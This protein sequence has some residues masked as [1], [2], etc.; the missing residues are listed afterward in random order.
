MTAN[1]ECP[2]SKWQHQQLHIPA[3]KSKL[4]KGNPPPQDQKHH[5]IIPKIL[6]GGGV[7]GQQWN[8]Q[9][10]GIQKQRKNP[11]IQTLLNFSH[12]VVQHSI[13]FYPIQ[14]SGF[15]N[16]ERLCFRG[17]MPQPFASWESWGDGGTWVLFPDFFS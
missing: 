9:E 8:Q 14:K 13:Y 12:F 6:A 17:L 3:N 2:S 1:S 4:C 11:K 10:L 7:R 5:H 15:S 16:S